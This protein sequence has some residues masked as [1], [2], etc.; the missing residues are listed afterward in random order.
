MMYSTTYE[1]INSSLWGGITI[2]IQCDGLSELS[3]EHI[4]K[5]VKK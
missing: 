3:R 5:K 4:F 1:N 2:K